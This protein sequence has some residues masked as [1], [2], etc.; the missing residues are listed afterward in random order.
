M[1]DDRFAGLLQ[2][3]P[4]TEE[5][6]GAPPLAGA[7][8]SAFT[9]RFA[10]ATFHHG[11]YRVHDSQSADQADEWVRDAF[12]KFPPGSVRCF[13]TDWRGRQWALDRRRQDA[14]GRALGLLFD[15]DFDSALAIPCGVDELHEG[16][17]P[18][19]I[20]DLLEFRWLRALCTVNPGVL[21]LP[22]GSCAG[23][24]VPPFL[25]GKVDPTNIRVISLDV[26]WTLTTQMLRAVEELPEGTPITGVTLR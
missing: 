2:V 9:D 8:A 10:G 15:I 7:E 13:A 6:R 17:L 19:S 18:E 25:N 21:P 24:S 16:V 20:E 4:L 11:V 22:Y 14:R 1:T 12:P 5:G 23:F 3:L 26:H